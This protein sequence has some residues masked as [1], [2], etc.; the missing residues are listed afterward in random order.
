MDGT[1][2]FNSLPAERL[3]RDLLACCAAPAWKA[4]TSSAR[5]PSFSIQPWSVTW[6]PPSA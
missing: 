4:P 5:T 6:P 2:A 3:E 1:E